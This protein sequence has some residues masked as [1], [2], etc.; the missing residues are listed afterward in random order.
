MYVHIVDIQT[1]SP[2]GKRGSLHYKLQ[3]NVPVPFT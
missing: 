2:G 3:D 1:F